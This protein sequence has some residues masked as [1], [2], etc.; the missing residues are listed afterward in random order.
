[1]MTPP[2]VSYH[3]APDLPSSFVRKDAIEYGFIGTLQKLKYEYRAFLTKY[4][5]D[6]DECYVWD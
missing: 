1:M 5:I 4:G 2:K 6:Y 3:D